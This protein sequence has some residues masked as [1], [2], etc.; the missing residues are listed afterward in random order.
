MKNYEQKL[1]GG[2]H[3][4]LGNTEAVVSEVLEDRQSFDELFNC[5][6]SDDE[7]VRLRV[8][9]AMKRITD[10]DKNIIIPYIDRFISEISKIDQASTQWTLSQ[11][12]LKLENDLSPGQRASAVRIMLNNL[13]DYKDWIV[14]NQTMITMTKWANKDD[15]ILEETIQAIEP[16]VS[17]SRK[18]VAKRAKISLSELE[19]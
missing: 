5:Y 4:S 13:R 16:L 6:F 9:S 8:S 19:H 17:D 1:K 12:F 11:L 2:H 3:N 18:S 10:A 7:L 14:L 15:D